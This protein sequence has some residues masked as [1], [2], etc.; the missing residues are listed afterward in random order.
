MPE[1]TFEQFRD[2]MREGAEKI[3]EQLGPEDD[4]LPSL[5]MDTP[6]GFMVMPLILPDGTE[7]FGQEGIPVVSSYIVMAKARLVCRVQMGWAATPVRGDKR[8][9]TDRPDRQEVLIIQVAEAGRQE[10]LMAEVTRH[11]DAPPELSEWTEAENAGGPLADA[12][13]AAVQVASQQEK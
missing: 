2:S 6:E 8:R 11:K 1:P 10:F 3:R 7:L 5:M 12:L 9:P 13:M 4:W